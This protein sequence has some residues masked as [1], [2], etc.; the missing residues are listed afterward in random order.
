MTKAEDLYRLQCL[1]REGDGKQRRLAEAERPGHADDV[2]RPAEWWWRGPFSSWSSHDRKAQ[3]RTRRPDPARLP[4]R[5]AP[6][7]D[8]VEA[9]R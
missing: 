2:Y 4:Y 5:P 3:E 6:W 7:P 8:R 1:D 9:E